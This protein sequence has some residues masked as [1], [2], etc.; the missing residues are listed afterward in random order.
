[1][2][3]MGRIGQRDSTSAFRTNRIMNKVLRVLWTTSEIMFGADDEHRCLDA[4]L[5][6][7]STS[8]CLVKA[9][10]HSPQGARGTLAA[11]GRPTA[12]QWRAA[13]A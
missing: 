3:M 8:G 1:M 4:R 5:V 10:L 9:V 11:G 6:E 13:R 2:R 12:G 7:Q